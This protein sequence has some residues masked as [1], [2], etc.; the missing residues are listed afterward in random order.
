MIVEVLSYYAASPHGPYMNYDSMLCNW[1]ML[2]AYATTFWNFQDLKIKPKYL[3]TFTVGL[4]QKGII[5]A[6][7]KKVKQFKFYYAVIRFTFVNI[8]AIFVL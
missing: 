5:D 4:N 3:V 2:N 8:K 7:V 6:A 1:S